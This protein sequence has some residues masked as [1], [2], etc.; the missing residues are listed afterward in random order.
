VFP[1]KYEFEYF[2]KCLERHLHWNHTRNEA[3]CLR[4]HI[5]PLKTRRENNKFC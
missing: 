4:P 3:H 5:Q 1:V 2:S